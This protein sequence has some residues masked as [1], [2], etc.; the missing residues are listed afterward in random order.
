MYKKHYIFKAFIMYQNEQKR[1]NDRRTKCAFTRGVQKVGK[2]ATL[3]NSSVIFHRF[4]DVY[5][6]FRTYFMLL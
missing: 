5:F 3:E 6:S 4:P 1:L 2:I